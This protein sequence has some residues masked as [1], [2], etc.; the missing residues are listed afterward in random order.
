MTI[1]ARYGVPTVAMHT[2]KFD[3]VVRSVAAVNGMSALRQVFVPQPIMGKT[4]AQL[5]AY[6]DGRDPLTGR[7]VMQEVVEGLTRPFDA[8]ELGSVI[9]DR[10]TPLTCEPDTEENLHRLFLESRWTDMLPIVLPTE[11]RVAAMLAQTHRKPDE[12]VGHMRSTHFREHWEYTVEKVAVNAVMAGARPEYFPV[13]LALA[14]TGVTA[15]SS[16]SSAMAAMAVV[17]GPVR[18]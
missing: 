8:A 1:E 3:R 12:I 5:R 18:R 17:N 2:D 7:P 10:S 14:A 6:V 15:R 4:P 9:F 16:S 13:V 11:E